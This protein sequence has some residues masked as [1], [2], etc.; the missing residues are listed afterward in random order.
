[1]EENSRYNFEYAEQFYK[2]LG[3]GWLSPNGEFFDC[4]GKVHALAAREL[5][6][7][8]E[9]ELEAKGYL[10]V[11]YRG[12]QKSV[13]TDVLTPAQREYIDNNDIYVEIPFKPISITRE[14]MMAFLKQKNKNENNN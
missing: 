13:F 8:S 14:Q 4:K 12:K 5:L 11:F 1:M 2:R 10:K 7:C 6:G 3:R 9:G